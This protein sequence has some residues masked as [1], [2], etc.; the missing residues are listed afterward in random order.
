MNVLVIGGNGFLGSHLVDFL[1]LKGHKIRVFDAEKE[2]YR[3]PLPNVEYFISSLDNTNNLVDA[4]FNIDI[5]FH[6]ASTSGSDLISDINTLVIPTIKLLDLM[7]ELG[8]NRLVYYSSGSA[9]Y[10]ESRNGSVNE[11]Q[12]LRP[13]TSYGI[14]KA[15]IEEYLM[16]YNYKKGMNILIIRSSNKYGPRQGNSNPKGVISTFLRKVIFKESMLVYGDGN[17]YKDYIYITDLIRLSCELCFRNTNGVFNLGNGVGISINQIL[18]KINDIT[19]NDLN[20]VYR[21]RLMLNN[22]DLVLDST[23]AFTQLESHSFISLEEG[24]FETWKWLKSI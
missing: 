21:P 20:I 13:L 11:E 19:N 23:K 24:I 16:L 9:I 3:Q 1:L 4:L 10:K 12:I 22:D 17:T 8:I 7:N 15:T 2:Y 14:I 5:V 18:E 6:A